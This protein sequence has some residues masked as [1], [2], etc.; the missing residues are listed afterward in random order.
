MQNASWCLDSFGEWTWANENESRWKKLLTGDWW[1]IRTRY[2]SIALPTL[3]DQFALHI[4]LSR[5]SLTPPKVKGLPD[6]SRDLPSVTY[7]Q[8]YFSA[9]EYLLTNLDFRGQRNLA[10]FW[11][12]WGWDVIEN[13]VDLSHWIMV[14]LHRFCFSSSSSHNF[15]TAFRQDALHLSAQPHSQFNPT[16]SFRTKQP[17]DQ[18]PAKH[19]IRIMR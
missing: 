2:H 4:F 3:Q 13:F 7:L 18:T 19:Q 16:S 14:A 11:R 17:Q 8:N 10:N 1:L 6:C 15:Y 5:D 9:P 12:G